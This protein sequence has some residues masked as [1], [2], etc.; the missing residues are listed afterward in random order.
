MS[1]APTRD[2]LRPGT[3]D[4]L[5]LSSLALGTMHGYAI[6]QHIERVSADVLRVEQGSL[7]PAL[8]RLQRKGWVTSAWGETPT[9]R[10]ARYYTIT[11]SG[12][13]R[14][15]EE[16]ARYDRVSLAIARVLDRA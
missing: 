16:L 12:R 4:M 14:L 3:L 11:D 2:E 8:D 13:A 9:K 7:Y 1:D 5:V 6:A 10:R 15:G